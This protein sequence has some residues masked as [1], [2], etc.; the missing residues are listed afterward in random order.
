MGNLDAAGLK[1]YAEANKVV[2]DEQAALAT[3]K[4]EAANEYTEKMEGLLKVSDP[5]QLD[6]GYKELEIARL[7]NASSIPLWWTKSVL[8]IQ[9]S[10]EGYEGNPL[11]LN[12]PPFY[13]KDVSNG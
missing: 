4:N 9:P 13:F 3:C 6:A 12:S 1:A 11:L 2:A 10:I 8:L 5:E 7:E